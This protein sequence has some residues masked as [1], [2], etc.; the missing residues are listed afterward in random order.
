EEWPEPVGSIRYRAAPVAQSAGAWAVA[1]QPDGEH[2]QE[3]SDYRERD[4]PAQPGCLQC[5]EPA[6][7]EPAGRRWHHHPPD[8]RAGRAHDAI[9]GEVDLVRRTPTMK[10]NR[11]A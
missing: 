8:I 10:S 5:S 3:H 11:F 6:G 7:N 4:A 9:H 1:D 2:L